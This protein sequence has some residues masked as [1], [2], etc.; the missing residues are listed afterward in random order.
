M[1]KFLS[2][3]GVDGNGVR[4]EVM[5]QT[6]TGRIK[7][8]EKKGRADASGQH[9]NV[10]VDFDPDNPLL[11][12][13]VY[14]LLD[15][16]ASDLWE[17]VQQAFADQRT[18]SFRIES[19]RKRGVDRTKKFEDLEHTEE[20]VRV[21]VA[22][23][24]IRSHES[25]TNPAEDPNPE[26]PS[27]LDQPL[28]AKATSVPVAAGPSKDAL[29]AALAAAREAGMDP[30]TV[31]TVAGHA[32]AAGATVEEV[33]TAGFTSESA[34]KTP[35]RA[36]HAVRAVAVEERPWVA[37][38][39]DG[40]INA[41]SYAVAHAAAAEQ[42]ALDHLVSTYSEGKKTAVDV[43]D[44]MIAQAASVALMLLDIADKVQEAAVGRLDRQK[45]SY[46]RAL[47]LV[48]DAV[49]KRHPVPV[50]GNDQEQ[51]EWK[52]AI[53][54][55]ASERLY[56]VLEVASGRLP[57]SQEEREKA[58]A[59]AAAAQANARQSVVAARLGATVL[60]PT[61]FVAPADAPKFGEK[62]FVAPDDTLI[63]RVK[64]VC[65]GAGVL[66]NQTGISQWFERATGQ[67]IAMHIHK[68]VFA[69]FV[70]HYETAGPKV[71][72]DEVGVPAKQAA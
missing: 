56:G 9:R 43:S 48:T 21:L 12:R 23:D 67:K 55:E 36:V 5:V 42:F 53:T 40:R 3:D 22:L 61:S 47:D 71:V 68:D 37:T 15:T 39:S 63:A 28:P 58:A 4:A 62:G 57:L 7:Q 45:N 33:N 30:V 24:G 60:P 51:G 49:A 32:L 10:A 70:E 50:G 17:Y 20:V 72:A 14:G 31:A 26:N 35:E 18:V 8:I 11:K 19:Q 65:E 54:A 27:A 1:S 44:E 66:T 2:H 29:L 16:T 13:R 41:G 46:G 38:N 64:A 25:K 34:P 59:A 69:A 52:E 6:G